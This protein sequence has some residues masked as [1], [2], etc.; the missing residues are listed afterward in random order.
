MWSEGEGPGK[1]SI[2]RLERF[3]W[4]PVIV[5]GSSSQPKIESNT[6]KKYLQGIVA[7]NKFC[8]VVL[9][10]GTEAKPERHQP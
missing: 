2:H 3:A 10:L 6:I 7:L 9:R 4:E 8:L 5:D 1:T